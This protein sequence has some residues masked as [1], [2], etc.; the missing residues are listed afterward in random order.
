MRAAIY[1]AGA[2]GT[3]LG[4]YIYS[5]GK[6]IDL[7]SRNVSHVQA[8]NE[9]GAKI[10]GGAEFTQKVKAITPDQMTGKYDIIFLMTK[11]R[12]N[13]ETVAYIARYLT[14]CG[15]IC[16]LQNGI[17]EPSVA[18]I[19]GKSRTLGCAVSWGAELVESGC[20][21]LTSKANKMTF[22]IGM[23]GG[24][25]PLIEEV[26]S[27]L[28]CAGF[29]QVEENFMGARWAKLAVNAAFSSLSA[30]TG[31]TF[32]E[33][34]KRK[35]YN[36][37][38]LGILNEAFDVAKADGVKIAPIQGYDIVKIY[39]N[40]GGVKGS[41]ALCLLP[42]AMMNHG[43]IVSGMRRDL[44]AGRVCDIDF[45]NG[46]IIQKGRQHGIPTPL[47]DRVVE[48]VHSMESG[49]LGLLDNNIKFVQNV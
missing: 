21:R 7:I 12:Q 41:I 4:A 38:A 47:C 27:F 40:H 9:K 42:L 1:G 23:I 33:I 14:D 32:G 2:M 48:V 49:K 20:V 29:A 43:N 11:Q 35:P 22:S 6:E 24:Y 16:T 25:C 18:E 15:V 3:V 17:P 45:I 46:V 31:L 13:A 39:G 19:I 37:L 8:L 36:R 30:V 28:G 26:E 34:A 5:A 44:L 10:V